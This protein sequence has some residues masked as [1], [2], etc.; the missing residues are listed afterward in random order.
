MTARTS[1]RGAGMSAT[2][3][4]VNDSIRSLWAAFKDGVGDAD[5]RARIDQA[6][7]ALKGHFD[8]PLKRMSISSDGEITLT[9]DLQGP[10]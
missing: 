6:W 8:W 7:T 3:A 9:I 5:S 10:K 1:H 4:G 2:R